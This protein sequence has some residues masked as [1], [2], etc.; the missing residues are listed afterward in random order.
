MFFARLP[1]ELRKQIYEYVMGEETIHLTLGTKKK[2]GHFIC[3]DEEKAGRE[4]T[5]RVLVGGRSSDRI[6]SACLN[7]LRVCRRMYV[8]SFLCDSNLTPHYLLDS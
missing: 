7:M 2:F 8:S 4:C 6:N 1:L 5:C 3:E